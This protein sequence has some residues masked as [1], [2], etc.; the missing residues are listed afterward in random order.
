MCG[1]LGLFGTITE[2]TLQLTEHTNTHF[3]TWYLKDDTN[4]ADDVEKMLQVSLCCVCF[5][6]LGGWVGSGWCSY[7]CHEVAELV[8][9][10]ASMM[11]RHIGVVRQ[12]LRS[13]PSVGLELLGRRPITF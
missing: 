13:F 8:A 6:M 1:G 12:R 4:L 9:G 3:S 7:S 2:L 10:L 5:C 11:R